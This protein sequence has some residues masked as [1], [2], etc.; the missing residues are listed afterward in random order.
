MITLNPKMTPLAQ[1][2]YTCTK[3][4]NVK[5][6]YIFFHIISFYRMPYNDYIYV[7]LLHKCNT[8]QIVQ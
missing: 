4:G 5:H 6:S 2:I 3:H 8:F 1:L 7:H